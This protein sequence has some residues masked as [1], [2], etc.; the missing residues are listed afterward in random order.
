MQTGKLDSEGD[1]AVLRLCLHCEETGSDHPSVSHLVRPFNASTQRTGRGPEGLNLARSDSG[2]AERATTGLL[3]RPRPA[4][5]P[6]KGIGK[7]N[8]PPDANTGL[9]MQTM[10][11]AG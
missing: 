6:R 1:A 11:Q 7:Q 9:S 8:P 10:M 2:S 4:H 3:S 5:E